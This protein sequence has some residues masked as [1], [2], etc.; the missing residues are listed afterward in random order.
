MEF[1]RFMRQK[2]MAR[3]RTGIPVAQESEERNKESEVQGSSEVRNEEQTAEGNTQ[4]TAAEVRYWQPA[5][6]FQAEIS[7]EEIKALLKVF[8][9]KFNTSARYDA[10]VPAPDRRVSHVAADGDEVIVYV[11]LFNHGFHLPLHPF[12]CDVLRVFQLAPA[13]LHGN[14]WGVLV[15]YL[16]ECINNK[17]TPSV[18]VI[19][20]LFMLKRNGSWYY[21]QSRNTKSFMMENNTH[22]DRSKFFVIKKKS[23][24]SWNFPVS[25][26]DPRPNIGKNPKINDLSEDQIN[27]EAYF[28]GNHFQIDNYIK[29]AVIKEK[30]LKKNAAKKTGNWRSE[31][32]C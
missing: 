21:L 8:G 13:Q 17:W 20:R 29:P 9:W 22:A 27:Q 14:A 3:K 2:H 16:I 31:F 11:D 24:D 1:V 6:N 30:L 23:D 5:D 19:R 25:W 15:T 26:R 18:T 7:L 28:R 12:L 4:E 32:F 10:Y